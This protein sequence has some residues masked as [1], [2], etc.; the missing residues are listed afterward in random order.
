MLGGIVQRMEALE[1]ANSPR[2]RPIKPRFLREE[3]VSD[4]VS[5]TKP[6]AG[7]HQSTGRTRAVKVA[8]CDSRLWESGLKINFSE[9][10]G[11][12]EKIL[13]VGAEEKKVIEEILV[14]GNV[15]D[16]LDDILEEEPNKVFLDNNPS[17]FQSK[18]DWE[19]PP[20][21]DEYPDEDETVMG[22]GELVNYHNNPDT[23]LL[24]EVEVLVLGQKEINFTELMVF[25][26]EQI[27]LFNRSN[28][29]EYIS[30]ANGH[31]ESTLVICSP[32]NIVDSFVNNAT[33]PSIYCWD[34]WL[35]EDCVLLFKEIVSFFF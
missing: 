3:E 28:F 20:K 5:I 17:S 27:D 24:Y 11:G 32:N 23:S 10:H 2:H 4:G 21:F 33:R 22:F 7:N 1:V 30:S 12:T 35:G 25:V 19:S 13:K 18:I 31:E 26:K 34:M 8:N 14:E 16:F 15:G 6:L 9:F 29:S